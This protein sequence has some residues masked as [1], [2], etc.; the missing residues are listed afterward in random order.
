[1][2][3]DATIKFDGVEVINTGYRGDASQQTA[4]NN[5][6]AAKGAPAETIV[7]VGSGSTSFFKNTATT[8]A[9]VEV[10]APMDGTAWNFTMACPAT[11]TDVTT[12]LSV[13]AATHDHDQRR[14]ELGERRRG[15]T[16]K[17][18]LQQAADAAAV[19]EAEHCPHFRRGH[20]P[21]SMRDRL[22]EQRQAVARRALG[23]P[24]FPVFDD[25]SV[26]VLQQRGHEHEAAG[27]EESHRHSGGDQRRSDDLIAFARTTKERRRRDHSSSTKT[28]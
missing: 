16:G 8:K 21:L 23:G 22:V 4:L 2:S 18:R 20:P 15:I 3:S 9:T 6:L 5:A 7:D 12:S 11:A 10:W 25:P 17:D 1:M 26:E 24:K 28:P 19:G 14:V 13:V 27:G